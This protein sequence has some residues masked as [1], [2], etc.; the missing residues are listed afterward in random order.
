MVP[1]VTEVSFVKSHPNV[2]APVK[3]SARKG[4]LCSSF[5]CPSVMFCFC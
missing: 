2:V 1:V 3:K 4:S 5:V